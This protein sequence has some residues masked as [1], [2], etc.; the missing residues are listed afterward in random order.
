MRYPVAFVWQ[1][2]TAD[3]SVTIPDLPGCS[4]KANNFEQGIF[5]AEQAIE[6]HLSLLAEYGETIP[7]PSSADKY[8]S[9]PNFAQAVWA[10][11]EIDIVPFLGK[12]QKINVTLPELLIR[13]IDNQVAKDPTYKTRSGFIASACLNELN[14]I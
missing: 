5:K 3:Y 4:T 11:V 14:K 2:S 1:T 6:E 12:S 8:L 7:Q 9:L 10:M 13:K